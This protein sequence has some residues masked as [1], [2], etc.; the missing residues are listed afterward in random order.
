MKIQSRGA[1]MSQTEMSSTLTNLKRFLAMPSNETAWRIRKRRSLQHERTGYSAEPKA[2]YGISFKSYVVA[3]LTN[4]FSRKHQQSLHT[5]VRTL[6][7]KWTTR[8][9]NNAARLNHHEVKLL[10]SKPI[11]LRKEVTWHRGPVV[12]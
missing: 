5:T 1:P 2:R 4:P 3:N 10:N 6:L 9:V 12:D 7:L 8:A 11:R